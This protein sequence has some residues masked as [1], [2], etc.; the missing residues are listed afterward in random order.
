MDLIGSKEGKL[1]YYLYD[2]MK[3]NIISRGQQGDLKGIYKEKKK[4]LLV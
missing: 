3:Q 1:L 2:L 4:D